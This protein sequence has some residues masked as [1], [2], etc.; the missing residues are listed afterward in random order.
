MPHYS[1]TSPGVAQ[2]CVELPREDFLNDNTLVLDGLH[3]LM[4][5][6]DDNLAE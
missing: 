3:S 6:I 1:R 4:A 2:M 5:S